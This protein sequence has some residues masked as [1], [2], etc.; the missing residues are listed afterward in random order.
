MCLYIRYFE[1]ITYKVSSKA[2]QTQHKTYSAPSLQVVY[3]KN[4]RLF[5]IGTFQPH[6]QPNFQL[7]DLMTQINSQSEMV[8]TWHNNTFTTNF[9]QDA[10]SR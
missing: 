5:F 6:C 10:N 8:K 3:E 9:I 7:Q 4:I 2:L 1:L